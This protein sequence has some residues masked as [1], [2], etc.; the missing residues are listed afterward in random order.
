MITDQEQ[1]TRRSVVQIRPALLNKDD[2]AAHLAIGKTKFDELRRSGAFHTYE[3]GGRLVFKVTELD[4]YAESL[5][6][7]PAARN[8]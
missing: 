1:Q 4:A 7:L 6:P 3:V 5:E 2:A 8:G